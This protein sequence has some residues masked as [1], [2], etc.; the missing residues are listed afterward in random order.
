MSDDVPQA[1]TRE[2]IALG[3]DEQWDGF[4]H[5]HGAR[6]QI[7]FHGAYCFRPE[8]TGP[9]FSAFAKDAQMIGAAE[10]HVI[11]VQVH[12]FMGSHAGVVEHS[13]QRVVALSK[14]SSAVDLSE[15]LQNLLTLQIFRRAS[16]VTL[17]PNREDGFT[18]RQEA[19][20]C[21]GDVLKE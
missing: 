4:I 9:F 21:F 20:V 6:R 17:K 10:P 12:Q 14:P 7:S 16:R 18:M 5:A 11:G 3:V 19:R 13:E 8:W 1:K 2:P 15:D